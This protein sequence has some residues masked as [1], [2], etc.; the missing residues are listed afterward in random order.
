MAFPDCPVG[1]DLSDIEIVAVELGRNEAGLHS[2]GV[3]AVV[4]SEVEI[5]RL[6]RR[7]VDGYAV[8][9]VVVAG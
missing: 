7:E 1:P 6:G 5:E 3:V 8:A 9:R 4:D 2:E